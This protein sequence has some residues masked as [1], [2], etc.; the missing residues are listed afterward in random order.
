MLDIQLLRNQPALVTAGLARRGTVLDLTPFE[1]LEAERKLVQTQ[2][3]DLQAKRNTLS[4][5]IGMLKGKEAKGEDVAPVMA[6]VMSEVAGLGDALKANEDKLAVLLAELDAFVSGIPN[7]PHES[8]PDGLNETG[9]V[10]VS[11][12][13]TPPVFDFTPKDHVELGEALGGLDFETG[14]KI[15]GSRFT[16]DEG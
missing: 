8:V 7:L 12:W 9:N 4:K 5:Q 10:E 11:R 16:L 3:Q 2:T 6:Q 13:G 1:K 14:V 15:A